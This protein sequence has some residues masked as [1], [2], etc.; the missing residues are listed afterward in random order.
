MDIFNANRYSL[1]TIKQNLD[2]DLKQNHVVGATYKLLDY[3]WR[4]YS[5]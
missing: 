2:Q 1:G 4:E 3:V 5:H